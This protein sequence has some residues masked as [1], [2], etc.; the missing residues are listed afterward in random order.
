MIWSEIGGRFERN[1]QQGNIDIEVNPQYQ[2]K[3]EYGPG[4][5][6]INNFNSIYISLG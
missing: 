4:S 6:I 2:K 3:P 1:Q 5:I